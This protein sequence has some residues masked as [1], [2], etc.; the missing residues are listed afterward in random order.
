MPK[1]NKKQNSWFYWS[2]VKTFGELKILTKASYLM[3]LLVPI[4]AGLWTNIAVFIEKINIDI[5]ESKVDIQNVRLQMQ[6]YIVYLENDST[7]I[8]ESYVRELNNNL[9][10][11]NTQIEER[12][13]I[14]Q[15]NKDDLK[16]L[17]FI[18]VVSFLSSIIILFAHLIYE[19]FAESLIKKNSKRDYQIKLKKEF[20]YSPSETMLKRAVYYI[21]KA[22][23][24]HGFL[25]N[26]SYDPNTRFPDEKEQRLHDLD[27]I[28]NGANAEYEYYNLVKLGWAV[29]SFILYVIGLLMILGILVNQT[30]KVLQ[31]AG[32]I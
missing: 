2:K 12:T 26:V 27:I 1:I 6:E 9:Q 22:K 3:I 23:E 8:K 16:K 30:Y 20:E 5:K 10:E 13:N 21:E 15:K 17:P 18:W 24:N 14:L 25:S 11:I 32:W 31:A 4:L 7:L 28:E 29:V 19:I